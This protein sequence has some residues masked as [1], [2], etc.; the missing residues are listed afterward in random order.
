M[1]LCGGDDSRVERVG[2]VDFR[3]IHQV[4]VL[5]LRPIIIGGLVLP[6]L[7]LVDKRDFFLEGELSICQ[8]IGTA[9]EVCDEDTEP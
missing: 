1:L 7:F 2:L 4:I 5:E 9:V 8:I 6:A 3:S